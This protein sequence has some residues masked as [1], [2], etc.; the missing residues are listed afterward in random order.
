MNSYPTATTI[1]SAKNL[2]TRYTNDCGYAHYILLGNC[3]DARQTYYVVTAREAKKL[4]AAG[5][6]RAE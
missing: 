3:T 4:V 1:Q 5:Y 2:Q 6:E